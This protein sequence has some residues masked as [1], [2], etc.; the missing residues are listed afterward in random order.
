M[1]EREPEPV[2]AFRAAFRGRR[3]SLRRAACEGRSGRSCSI[4]SPSPGPSC[5]PLH[6][7]SACAPRIVESR[8]RSAG[9]P[10][11]GSTK[12]R[13]DRARYGKIGRK[14]QTLC[15]LSP[16]RKSQVQFG[17]SPP[18]R[19]AR[20]RIGSPGARLVAVTK[21]ST[22][23]SSITRKS[24][25]AARNSASAARAARSAEESPAEPRKTCNRSSSPANQ[26]SASS[27]SVSASSRPMFR[28][29]STI[30]GKPILNQSPPELNQEQRILIESRTGR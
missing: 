7:P 19:A 12:T 28:T 23:T 22:Q 4:L 16:R 26:P 8:E 14:E 9:N 1:A 2:R 24:S 27:A 20:A 29:L 6:E 13:P 15:H 5:M 17:R 30:F 21:P 18:G 11:V 10:H 3:S 25:T